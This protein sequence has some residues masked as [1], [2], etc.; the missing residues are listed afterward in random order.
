M[1]TFGET[2]RRAR[3]EAKMTQVQLAAKAGVAQASISKAESA[4]SFY[5]A[6]RRETVMKIASALGVVISEATAE[7][8]PLA[9]PAATVPTTDGRERLRKILG[10]AF[11]HRVHDVDDLAMVRGI[12]KDLN[13]GFSN[14]AIGH[15]EDA[16]RLLLLAAAGLRQDFGGSPPHPAASLALNVASIAAGRIRKLEKEIERLHN[17]QIDPP[18]TDPTK[19]FTPD[20]AAKYVLE[21]LATGYPIDQTAMNVLVKA[22]AEMKLDNEMTRAA[23]DPTNP[24]WPFGAAAIAVEILETQPKAARA[25]R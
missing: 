8:V 2:L 12:I 9:S 14:D 22:A 6:G 3:E 24:R 23:A 19:P 13:Y 25:K 4:E 16:C 21:C 15:V 1:S 20:N 10:S 11:D 17:R 18:D 5:G 7:I